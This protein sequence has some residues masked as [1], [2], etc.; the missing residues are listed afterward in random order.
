MAVV[1]V[2][3]GQG[4]PVNHNAAALEAILTNLDLPDVDDTWE[5]DADEAAAIQAVI[6][7]DFDTRGD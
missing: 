4:A 7:A 3:D 5:P 2:N 6:D 1:Q